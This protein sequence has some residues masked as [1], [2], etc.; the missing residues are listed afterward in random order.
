MK[1]RRCTVQDIDGYLA[2][3]EE[4][5]G[6]SMAATRAQLESRVENFGDGILVGEADNHIVAALSFVR[7]A[8]YDVAEGRSWN[9]LTDHGWCGN[10]V[11]DGPILFGVDLSVSRLAPRSASAKMFV[12]G[13]EL[14]M[15]MGVEGLYWG[16]RLPRY[17]RYAGEMTAEE[18]LWA[19]NKR[20]KHLDPEIQ[21]YSRVPGLQILGVVPDYFKDWES[22]D[23]GAVL[24]WPNP[25]HRYPFLRPFSGRILSLLYALDRRRSR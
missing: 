4:E 22:A 2:I 10:H 21:L 1:V 3:Q 7:L 15:R 18:Y 16:S 5:W 23:N 13:L 12:A 8:S 20:G 14:T 11:P 19:K 24:R 6:E 17:H 9:D 25:I